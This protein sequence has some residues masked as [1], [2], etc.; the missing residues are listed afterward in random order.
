MFT[1]K[2]VISAPFEKCRNQDSVGSEYQ[3]ECPSPG[4]SKLAEAHG[5]NLLAIPIGHTA[6]IYCF[7][8]AVESMVTDVTGTTQSGSVNVV[9]APVNVVL[10]IG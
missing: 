10:V 5:C 2:D 8:V 3:R 6:A 1:V 4:V 9:S 7:T